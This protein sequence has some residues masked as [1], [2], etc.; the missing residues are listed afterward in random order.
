MDF[1]SFNGFMIHITIS[2]QLLIS[3]KSIKLRCY[4]R[5]EHKFCGIKNISLI[6]HSY[7]TF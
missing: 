5:L 3:D 7:S 6:P 2:V 1:G 4:C